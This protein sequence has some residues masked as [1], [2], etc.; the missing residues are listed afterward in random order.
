M[1]SFESLRRERERVLWIR[2]INDLWSQ[3]GKPQGTDPVTVE[4][5]P[6][7]LTILFSAGYV[8]CKA[9]RWHG[10]LLSRET[11]GWE[12]VRP[13]QQLF[14]HG[15]NSQ[16][17]AVATWRL[18]LRGR[19]QLLHEWLYSRLYLCVP[20][21]LRTKMKWTL[22]SQLY[23]TNRRTNQSI[24]LLSLSHSLSCSH[25]TSFNSTMVH[26]AFIFK[27]PLKRNRLWKLDTFSMWNK[28]TIS[29]Q[30]LLVV[31]VGTLF[32]DVVKF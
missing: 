15:T 16:E 30:W 12:Q 8:G 23:S 25:G 9:I 29:R 11:V 31:N 20:P 3:H 5:R 17:V 26:F 27:L 10:T 4:L 24:R 21:V 6:F 1:I 28:A 19:V 22:L 32:K 14:F 2:Y 7:S 13:I 18:K